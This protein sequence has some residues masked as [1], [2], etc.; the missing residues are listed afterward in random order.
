MMKKAENKSTTDYINEMREMKKTLKEENLDID[1]QYFV[2][3]GLLKKAT[4]LLY[5]ERVNDAFDE[6]AKAVEI[7]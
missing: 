4:V 5:Y 6:I 2:K 7:G 3:F 1:D